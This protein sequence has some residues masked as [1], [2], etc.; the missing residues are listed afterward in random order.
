[1]KARVV[2]IILAVVMVLAMMPVAAFADT[3]ITEVFLQLDRAPAVGEGLV[4]PELYTVNGSTNVDEMV[5]I[6]YTKWYA[7]DYYTLDGNAYGGYYNEE[8]EAGKSYNLNIEL[9]PA[10]GYVLAEDCSVVIMAPPEHFGNGYIYERS[11]SSTTVAY[12]FFFNLTD[13]VPTIDC[14]Q[15]ALYAAPEAGDYLADRMPELESVNENEEY[16]RPL[17]FR[18]SWRFYDEEDETYYYEEDVFSAER[19]YKLFIEVFAMEAYVLAEEFELTVRLGDELISGELYGET[20]ENTATFMF[21]VAEEEPL[22]VIES[23]R[24]MA[25][26]DV[27]AGGN[28]FSFRSNLVNGEERLASAIRVENSWGIYDAEEEAYMPAASIV[29]EEGGKYAADIFIT[30]KEGYVLDPDC[31]ITIVTPTETLIPSVYYTDESEIDCVLKFDLTN[32]IEIQTITIEAPAEPAANATPFA[33]SVKTVNGSAADIEAVEI[34]TGWG[35]YDAEEEA[36]LP[37]GLIPFAAGELYAASIFMYAAAG[38]TFAEDC[39]VLVVAPSDRELMIEYSDESEIDGVIFYEA[40]AAS[41][42]EGDVDG[43]G[44]VDTADV[45]TLLCAIKK[46]GAIDLAIGDINGDGKV[47]LADA[48]RLLKNISK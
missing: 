41:A 39:E 11:G 38:Y 48:L 22:T 21:D 25:P 32:Q 5:A 2:S 42:V 37:N 12:D 6:T 35:Q 24:L 20:D 7:C 43:N 1:M 4:Y 47:S 16:L 27:V 23:I 46:G 40:I 26:V 10:D 9:T 34:M 18:A 3:E 13:T 28:S 36:Y 44:D 17:D 33:F 15:F 19:E 14:A 45:V 31:E 29:F 8:F 30:T